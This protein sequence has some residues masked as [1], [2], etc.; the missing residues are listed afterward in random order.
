[1]EPRV[2]ARDE[3]RLGQEGAVAVAEQDA[4]GASR[5]IRDDD[6]GFAVAIEI[7]GGNSYRAGSGGEITRGRQ[8]HQ[9]AAFEVFER[10][11]ARG[12]GRFF[13][14]LGKPKPRN[15]MCQTRGI[16][17]VFSRTKG[18]LCPLASIL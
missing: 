5:V 15:H 8:A 14:P 11:R 7:A 3:V 9:D 16:M 4:H 10:R 17:S 18:K 2:R 1:M 6:V 13:E 12:A